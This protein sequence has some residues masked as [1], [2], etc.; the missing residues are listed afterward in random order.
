MTTQVVKDFG[1]NPELGQALQSLLENKANSTEN[2]VKD[3]PKSYE[4][5]LKTDSNALK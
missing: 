1:T 2:W 5:I 3:R 4:G